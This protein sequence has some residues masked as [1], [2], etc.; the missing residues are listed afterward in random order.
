MA[1]TDLHPVNEAVVMFHC[2]SIGGTPVAAYARAPF[3]GTILKVGVVTHGVITTADCTVTPATNTTGSFAN[4]TG[5]AITVP[6]SGAAAGQHASAAP[7][8]A[9]TVN[10]DDVIR[11]TPAGASGA[12]IAATFY[13]VVR[14]A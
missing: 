4:I 1:L 5:G 3:R 10:E 13:A 9:N 2:P 6:V 14:R 8:G 7:T 12:S 11:F